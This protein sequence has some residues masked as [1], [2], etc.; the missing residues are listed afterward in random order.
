MIGACNTYGKEE[1]YIQSFGGKTGVKET[2]WKTQ[3]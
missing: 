3:A 2:T 1:S